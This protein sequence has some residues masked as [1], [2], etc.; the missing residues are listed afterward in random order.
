MDAK[1]A[2]GIVRTTP[3]QK[4]PPRINVELNDKVLIL[5]DFK[6]GKTT[7]ATRLLSK[8]R[9]FAV[10]DYTHFLPNG[11]SD[12]KTFKQKFLSTGRAIYQPGIKSEE[13]LA[14]EFDD[15]C[16]FMLS[17]SYAMVFIDEPASVMNSRSMGAG[18]SNFYRLGHKRYLGVI[19]ATHRYHGDIPALTRIVN[20]RFIFRC[21]VD[22]DIDALVG[23]IGMEGAMWVKDAPKYAYWY[24]GEAYNGPM[25]PLPMGGKSPKGFK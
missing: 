20:H 17:Q 10:W 13:A 24:R 11:T 9:R 8:F 16:F 7:L 1:S 12:L 23:D 5:G 3:P 2:D 19:L 22:T 21:G 25:P 14:A 18:F 15:F 4:T 6:M